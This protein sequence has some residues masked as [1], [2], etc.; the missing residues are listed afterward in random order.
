M[1]KEPDIKKFLTRIASLISM[2]LLWM[3]VNCTFGIGL[4]LAFFDD[5][6]T[7]WNYIFYGWFALS[8]ILLIFYFRRKMQNKN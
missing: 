4:N 8:F 5:K 1:E 7:L 2:T 3:L 6:P